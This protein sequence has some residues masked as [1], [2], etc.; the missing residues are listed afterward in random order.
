M[1]RARTVL[2]LALVCACSFVAFVPALDGEWLNWDDETNF[3]SNPHFRGLG[4][5]Q[6]AWMFTTT[7]LAVY[8]PLSWMSL[9]LNYALDGMNPWGYHLGNLLLHSANAGL[10]FV[11]ARRLLAR[12]RAGDDAGSSGV[13]WGAAAAALAWALHP[14][15]VESVAWVTERRDVLAGLFY[16]AAIWAYLKAVEDD[17]LAAGWRL[18][19]LGAFAAALLAKGLTMTLPLTLLVLDA[20][21][22][23]RWPRIGWAGLIREKAPYFALSTLGALAALWAVAAE[24][25]WTSYAEK[26]PLARLAMVGY[27][28]WF[29]PWKLLWPT[30]LSPLYEIPEHVSLAQWR[31]LGPLL[32]AALVTAILVVAR[33]RWPA[34]LAAWAHSAIVIAPV[35]GIVHAGP[36]LAHA[37][38]SDL[39][40]LGFALL[41]GA[42]IAWLG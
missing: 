28:V 25:R 34:G 26:G 4:R 24:A 39:S 11:V 8:I 7:L 2:L 12:A 13:E 20:Y 31:F 35:R 27:S 33:R 42:A 10:F 17:R 36:Q 37:R 3:V 9:G 21:P 18:A 6:L 32:G 15:R 1:G 14:L 19:S 29:Y 5:A 22:L 40:S 16:V 23:R 38:F 30:E 41:V